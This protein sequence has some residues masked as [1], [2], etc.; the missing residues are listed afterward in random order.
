MLMLQPRA[1]DSRPLP[2][3]PSW[4]DFWAG[5]AHLWVEASRRGD[6]E[7]ACHTD[8]DCAFAA[9]GCEEAPG[10]YCDKI[11][12]RG[13]CIPRYTPQTGWVAPA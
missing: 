10:Y 3:A 6:C 2:T 13:V 9:P 5:R 1:A 4:E 11:N 12:Y 8:S 7:V